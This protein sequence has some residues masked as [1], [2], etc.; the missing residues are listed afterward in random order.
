MGMPMIA[1]RIHDGETA[2]D[3]GIPQDQ[4]DCRKR[5]LERYLA[6]S[7]GAF[8]PRDYLQ[9]LASSDGGD[10]PKPI[11]LGWN[12]SKP[13]RGLGDTVA[14]ITHA[15]G[16]DKIAKAYTRRTGRDCGCNRRQAKLNRLMPYK[17]R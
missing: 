3:I 17:K 5:T 12:T 4:Y 8:D 11:D 9:W 6:Q 7:N 10:H 2:D 16:L 1:K 13:S 14:K 15:T